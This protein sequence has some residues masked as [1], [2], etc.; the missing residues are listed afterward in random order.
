MEGHTMLRCCSAT[1]V[2]TTSMTASTP[3]LPLASGVRL[4]VT[5]CKDAKELASS[6][7][8]A[9]NPASTF[10]AAWSKRSP[11]MRMSQSEFSSHSSAVSATTG[12]ASELD[13]KSLPRPA[14]K[15]NLTALRAPWTTSCNLSASL[16]AAAGPTVSF[17]HGT[18][19]LASWAVELLGCMRA[20]AV[21]N[22]VLATLSPVEFEP[23]RISMH[24]PNACKACANFWTLLALPP[25]CRALALL[26]ELD[27]CCSSASA[28][29][30]GGL[31]AAP[32][33]KCAKATPKHFK[34][35]MDTPA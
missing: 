11:A 34:Q 10:K 26:E 8:R 25:S 9:T 6:G 29:G 31:L 5:A 30:F 22:A 2:Q 13:R 35:L 15:P 12:A 33:A 3:V 4:C 24:W 7:D 19:P 28:T 18:P 32:C 17:A 21:C 27:A 23:E 20:E 14:R 1:P 16:A